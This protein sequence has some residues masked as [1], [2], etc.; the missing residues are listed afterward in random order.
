MLFNITIL[1]GDDKLDKVNKCY[2]SEPSAINWARNWD[3]LKTPS[4]ELQQRFYR[5]ARLIRAERGW[6]FIKIQTE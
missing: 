6:S 3:E 2:Y 5:I 1:R 4:I